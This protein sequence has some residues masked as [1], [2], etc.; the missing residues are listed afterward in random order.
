MEK[1]K[2]ENM[3]FAARDEMLEGI[4]RYCNKEKP[5]DFL[6]LGQGADWETHRICFSGLDAACW[7]ESFY[8]GDARQQEIV[9]EMYASIM[10]TDAR[11]IEP[12][13]KIFLNAGLKRVD[14]E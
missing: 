2:G 5:K 13:R 7:I 6:P 14:E 3:P 9:R 10:F 4:R 1:Y 12:I 11:K 8:G